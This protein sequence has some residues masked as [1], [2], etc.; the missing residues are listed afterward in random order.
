MACR[1][2]GRGCGLGSASLWVWVKHK[3]VS[4]YVCPTILSPTPM[5]RTCPVSQQEGFFD[6]QALRQSSPTVT[7]LAA[8]LAVV[9]PDPLAIR[10]HDIWE[11]WWASRWEVHM[12]A[13]Q[14]VVVTI[15]KSYLL[16]VSFR[17]FKWV[18]AESEKPLND[19]FLN[20]GLEKHWPLALLILGCVFLLPLWVVSGGIWQTHGRDVWEGKIGVFKSQTVRDMTD[21]V[22]CVRIKW[23][24][25]IGSF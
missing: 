23:F 20:Q 7:S 25:K 13:H 3:H 9:L 4:I 24:F 8:L 15:A 18:A 22:A 10:S 14:L 2:N 5:I 17:E 19:N 11:G 21:E 16:K 12:A 1:W 6:K